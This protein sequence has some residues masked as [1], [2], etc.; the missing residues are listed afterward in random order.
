MERVVMIFVS[1]MLV[2]GILGC[3]QV[4]RYTLVFENPKD[5]EIITNESLR[6]VIRVL[7]ELKT[8]D[9]VKIVMNDSTIY[10]SKLKEQIDFET[11][12]TEKTNKL[13]VII[14]RDG[15]EITRRSIMFSF[16]KPLIQV[17]AK[18]KEKY[19]AVRLSGIKKY[20]EIKPEVGVSLIK[21]PKEEREY[22]HSVSLDILNEKPVGYFKDVIVITYRVNVFK[23][24][25]DKV[26][27]YVKG[28]Y[29]EISDEM[30]NKVFKEFFREPGMT[31]ELDISKVPTGSYSLTVRAEDKEGR[32]YESSRWVRVDKTPPK[33]IIE[34]LT[35]N[36]VVRGSYSFSII[37]EDPSGILSFSAEIDQQKLT[38]RTINNKITFTFDSTKIKNG[39][40]EVK[41]TVSDKLTNVFVTNIKVFIDNWFEK[42]VDNTPGAGFNVSAFVDEDETVY[43]A[44]YNILSKVLMFAYKTKSMDNWFIE[45]VDKTQDSGKYPSIF[46][47]R[48]GRIHIAYTY[49]NEKWDD[50]DLKY[51]IKEG[52]DWNTMVL[53]SQDKAGR[54]TS[55]VVDSKGIPHISYYNYTV[56]SLRYMTYNIKM[57]RWEVSVPDSYENVGSDT[58]IDLFQDT[59]HIVYLDNA[60]GDLKHCYKRI[61]DT[62]VGWKFEVI[63][64]EGKVGYYA[65]MKIDKNGNI[66]V[67]YYDATQKALKYAV[68][69]GNVWKISVIDK[70]DDPGRFVSLYVD[71]NGNIHISY[72]VKDREEIRYAF[73]DGRSWDI[74][75]VVSGK[76]GGW[77][78]VVV[79]ED[80]PMIFFY[81]QKSN[82]LK[83]LVK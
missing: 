68:K 33:V 77:S 46:V 45:T 63:D 64:S 82:N 67:A 7:G 5:G 43:I 9:D 42:V 62:D 3:S 83:V 52:K 17:K 60:N 11:Q 49:I 53:D 4:D 75:T 71:K 28:V 2:V 22:I 27:D 38:Y 78:S 58:S 15:A 20:E 19:R 34:N 36:S 37:P 74:Q 59:I 56:G 29:V 80:K 66:H 31:L 1:I 61:E 6:I 18:K 14:S 40:S 12:I 65:K 25:A 32:T 39:I 30:D 35:N 21:E 50:E 16:R 72:F 70:N 23:D 57:N 48:F 51:A 44:Y 55:I 13:E 10:V 47:D 24:I 69:S 41:I 76:A 8:E 79:V 73:F 54:Y 81:D 26:L